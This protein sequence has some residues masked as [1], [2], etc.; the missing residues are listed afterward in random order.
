[1]PR[2]FRAWVHS[3]LDVAVAACAA[4]I[5]GAVIVAGA[6]QM[7]HRLASADP[8]VPLT[9]TI[10]PWTITA[11]DYAVS[12]MVAIALLL[13]V[14]TLTSTFLARLDA[15]LARRHLRRTWQVPESLP[16]QAPGQEKRNY[17]ALLVERNL[18]ENWANQLSAMIQVTVL[19]LALAYIGGWYE[20]VGMAVGLT[21]MAIVSLL[22]WRRARRV[23]LAFM[24]VRSVV[25]RGP[26]L[27]EDPP[28]RAR[29]S[30]T[31]CTPGTRRPCGWRLS[32]PSSCPSA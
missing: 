32:S 5:V 21:L 20:A 3:T 30:S 27:A 17:G 8:D 13:T 10:G 11:P 18:L 24:G 16:G 1:V 14:A 12:L 29:T 2:D 4:S 19:S 26:A 23:S 15:R 9:F 28:S 6:M 7:T 31:R 22:F 25:R